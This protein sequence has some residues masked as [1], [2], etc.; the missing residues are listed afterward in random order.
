MS[1]ICVSY[2]L[3]PSFMCDFIFTYGKTNRILDSYQNKTNRGNIKFRETTQIQD[4]SLNQV[5]ISC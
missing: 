1:S 4:L 3:T 5:L 2:V